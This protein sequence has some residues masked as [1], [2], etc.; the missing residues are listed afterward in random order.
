VL[1]F[2]HVMQNIWQVLLTCA[3]KTDAC[4][5]EARRLCV[6]MWFALRRGEQDAVLAKIQRGSTLAGFSPAQ[7]AE[8]SRL[9]AYLERH[10]EHIDYQRYKE[11]GLPT[12]SGMVEST[13][14][15]LIQQRFKGVGM[16]WSEEGFT[17]LL[18]LRL[19]WVNG[20]FDALFP[21]VPPQLIDAPQCMIPYEPILTR[22]CPLSVPPNGTIS[23][24]LRLAPP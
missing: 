4:Q 3:D 9:S 10:R 17:H 8:L 14:K 20:R 2:Y 12:G 21:G 5:A 6:W 24:S 18:H 11:L 13:C 7:Q 15:W 23:A 19:C 16:R 22:M 1:D